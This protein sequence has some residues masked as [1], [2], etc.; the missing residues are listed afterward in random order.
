M[1]SQKSSLR[2]LLPLL[3]CT[4]SL[5]T[6]LPAVTI[7]QTNP[8]FSLIW[9]GDGPSRKQQL[10]YVL[11]YGTPRHLSDRY[12]LLIRRQD[13]AIDGIKII[14]PSKYDG[15]IQ[16][17]RISLRKSPKGRIFNFNRGEPIEVESVEMEKLKGEAGLIEIIPKEVIPAGTAFEVVVNGVRNPSSGTYYFNCRVTSPGDL[18]MSRNVGTWIISFFRS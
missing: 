10:N 16:P 8:G 15:K 11:E 9:G 14:I 2:H 5:L 4:G 13:V 1:S 7:A 3:V 17:E 6:G 12:R 18:P